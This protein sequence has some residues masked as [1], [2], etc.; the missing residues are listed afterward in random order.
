MQE[1]TNGSEKGIAVG[2]LLNKAGKV[3]IIERVRKETGSDGSKLTWVFPGGRLDGDE[4]FEQ[5]VVREVLVE[6]GYHVKVLK[7]IS[8]RLHPQFDVQI[9]YYALDFSEFKITP[10]QEVHEVST[11]KWVEPQ[12]LD[13]YFTTDIDTGVAKYLKIKK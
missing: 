1:Q 2:I 4:T 3:L 10:I 5:A 7:L 11:L 12:E 9:K 13:N 8:E 6:T